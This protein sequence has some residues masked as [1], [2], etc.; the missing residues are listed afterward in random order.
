MWVEMENQD[1]KVMSILGK[2]N[3]CRYIKRKHNRSRHILMLPEKSSCMRYY[4]IYK[5]AFI[6]K[7]N[8]LFP[9]FVGKNP[10]YRGL[11]ESINADILDSLMGSIDRVL[12]V[13]PDGKIYEIYPALI[14]RFCRKHGLERVQDKQNSYNQ[15]FG[16]MEEVQ[17]KTY[18]FPIRLLT[19]LGEIEVSTR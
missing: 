18:C 3:G 19:R 7:F 5:K 15:G 17:E 16:K 14:W 2:L 6:S 1:V 9:T 4:V 13:Y 12:Y 11:G 10:E 8:E